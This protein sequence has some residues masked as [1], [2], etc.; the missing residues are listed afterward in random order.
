MEYCVARRR[1][2]YIGIKKKKKVTSAL[3]LPTSFDVVAEC[4]ACHDK[5]LH[6]RHANDTQMQVTSEKEKLSYKSTRTAYL[7]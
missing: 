7:L 6:F 4:S 5:T 1:F 3:A 2:E